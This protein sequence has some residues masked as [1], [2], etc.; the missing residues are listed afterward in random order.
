[1]PHGSSSWYGP[2]TE[3]EKTVNHYRPA[4]AAGGPGGLVDRAAEAIHG[5]FPLVPGQPE[6]PRLG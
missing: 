3:N 1:M 5:L 2:V 6:H 4:K